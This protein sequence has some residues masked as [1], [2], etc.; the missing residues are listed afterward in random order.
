MRSDL[1]K[2]YVGKDFHSPIGGT[3]VRV[4]RAQGYP[5]DDDAHPFSSA[6]YS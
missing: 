5:Y 6:S 1:N 3:E 2:P 4:S